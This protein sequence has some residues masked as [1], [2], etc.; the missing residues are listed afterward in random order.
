MQRLAV[1]AKLRPGTSE[2]AANLVELGP[3]FDPGQYGIERH[4][5]FLAADLVVFIFEGGQPNSL[6]AALGSADNQSV[7]AAWEPLLDSTPSIA[8]E[9][10]HWD[11]PD[12]RRPQRAPGRVK[13]RRYAGVSTPPRLARNGVR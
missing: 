5:V 8:R 1:I 12:G 9:V 13:P 2:E 10:Y 6:L 11:S 4:S 3:P 7:L